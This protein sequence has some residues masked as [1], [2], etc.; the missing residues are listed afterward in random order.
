MSTQF[1]HLNGKEETVDR[2]LQL[3][4]GQLQTLS[5]APDLDAER[6][7]LHVLGRRESSWL[8]AHG[9]EIVSPASAARYQQFVAE[10]AAGKP[11]A[12]LLGEQEFYGRSFLVT[13]DV[14]IPRPATEALIDEALHYFD[15]HPHPLVVADIGTGS[16][17][18]AI[19]LLL[20][21]RL[22]NYQIQLLATDI[23]PA[24]LRVARQNAERHGMADQ[25]EWLRGDMLAPLAGRAVD[26]VVSNPPYVPS[27]ELAAPATVETR[28][29]RFEPQLALDGGVDGRL[30][31]RQLKTAGIPAVMESQKGNVL[32]LNSA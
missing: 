20:E 11:L 23:S 25:I 26:L 30:Y 32:M 1:Q 8:Y 5:D 4:R 31:L 7:L 3:A 19:T 27:A 16:G 12:Y 17:C 15:E 21:A 22:R 9:D 2:L 24:A 6:L 28:G 29:L 13:E 18:I 14:L 10:R